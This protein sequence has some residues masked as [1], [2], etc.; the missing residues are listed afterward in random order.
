MVL[1]LVNLELLRYQYNMENQMQVNGPNGVMTLDKSLI[2][3]AAAMIQKNRIQINIAS[4]TVGS[5]GLLYFNGITLG[6]AVSFQ[7]CSNCL[8][9]GH[10]KPTCT[11]PRHPSVTN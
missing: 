4:A 3:N 11:N 9:A 10:K 5:D 2:N 6:P 8:G 7:R 1:V